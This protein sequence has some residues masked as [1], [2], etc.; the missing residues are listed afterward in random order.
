MRFP[1]KNCFLKVLEK[2]IFCYFASHLQNFKRISRITKITYYFGHVGVNLHLE[3]DHSERSFE[4]LDVIHGSR[5][6]LGNI[7]YNDG[8]TQFRQV[9]WVRCILFEHKDK[10]CCVCVKVKNNS[11]EP[12]L[13]QTPKRSL[14]QGNVF[15]SLCQSFC[16][17]GGRGLLPDKDPLLTETPRKETQTKTPLWTETLQTETPPRQRLPD[18]D[19][20]SGKSHP[21]PNKDHQ[22]LVAAT[23][24]WNAYLFTMLL[25]YRHLNNA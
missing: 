21:P 8:V 16:S 14:S 7:I 19:S 11:Q 23:E 6:L 12:S 20:V 24:A 4:R 2:L 1:D 9:H 10:L 17:Q 5:H 25:C 18:R 13:S 3:S 22:Y 15:I